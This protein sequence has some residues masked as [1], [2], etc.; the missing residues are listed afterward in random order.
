M[1][2]AG[3]RQW[4]VQVSG[5][6]VT[7]G[8]QPFALWGWRD[9]GASA[10]AESPSGLTAT[11]TSSSQIN[12]AWADGSGSED[13]FKIQRRQGAGYTTFSQ[14]ATVQ[15]LA[16][17]VSRCWGCLLR[18]IAEGNKSPARSVLSTSSTQRIGEEYAYCFD[19]PNPPIGAWRYLPVCSGRLRGRRSTGRCPYQR[20]AVAG[21]CG[22][23]TV[24][25]GRASSPNC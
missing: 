20:R 9:S 5:A 2:S 3:R 25:D 19:R 21:H 10:S 14:L 23:H 4:I 1:F 11:S 6:N 16:L 18:A 24:A 7:E 8:S 22:I 13:G 17:A 12:L 15:K